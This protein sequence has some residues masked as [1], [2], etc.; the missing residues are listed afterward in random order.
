MSFKRMDILTT[1]LIYY[2]VMSFLKIGY[3]RRNTFFHSSSFSS[4]YVYVKVKVERMCLFIYFPD[5]THVKVFQ[6]DGKLTCTSRNP[7]VSV[8]CDRLQTHTGMEPHM[9][10]MGKVSNWI[11]MIG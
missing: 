1:W 4:E 7:W 11:W 8:F 5:D 6:Q 2:V 10:A 9:S 3:T